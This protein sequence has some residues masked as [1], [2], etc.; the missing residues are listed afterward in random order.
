MPQFIYVMRP[1]NPEMA[2]N[3]DLWTEADNKMAEDHFAYLTKATEAGQVVLAGR[4][5]DDK[6]PAVVIFEA[7]NEDEAR[8]FMEGDP[9]VSMGFANVTLHPYRV[10]LQRKE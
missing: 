1:V 2:V 4:S 5:L 6:G 9:F 8:R 3:P 10:A 7:E